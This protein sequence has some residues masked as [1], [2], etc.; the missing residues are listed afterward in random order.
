MGFFF[1][2]IRGRTCCITPIGIATPGNPD[3]ERA[4]S[5]DCCQHY[6]YCWE[7]WSA[8]EAAQLG[9]VL[10]ARL[11]GRSCCILCRD[12]AS[13]WCIRGTRA[14]ALQ[15]LGTDKASGLLLLLHCAG[16]YSRRWS[17]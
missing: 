5:T 15:C 3:F 6:R 1:F 10:V 16:C 12:L 17:N 4:P 7:S 11:S 13:S 8:T 14:A 9:T 2:S